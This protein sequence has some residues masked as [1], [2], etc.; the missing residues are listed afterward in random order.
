MISGSPPDVYPAPRPRVGRRG[1]E[2]A[3]W[4]RWAAAVHANETESSKTIQVAATP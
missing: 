4:D 3:G 2:L 1:V